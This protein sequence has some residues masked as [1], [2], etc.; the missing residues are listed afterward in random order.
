MTSEKNSKGYMK[1]KINKFN[2][3]ENKNVTF[4]AG[5]LVNLKMVPIYN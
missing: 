3:S 4:C 5:A 1:D 2:T